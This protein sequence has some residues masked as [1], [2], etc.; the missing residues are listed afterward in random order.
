MADNSYSAFFAEIRDR[1]SS[2]RYNFMSSSGY[3]GAYQ[4]AEI[5]MKNLGY[6]EGDSTGKQDWIGDFTGKDG[7]TSKTKLLTTP[8][9]QDKVFDNMLKLYW[10]YANYDNFHIADH[11]GQTIDGIPVTESLVLAASHL[12]GIGKVREWQHGDREL[13]SGQKTYF[14]GL[15]GYDI[16]WID[17]SGSDDG[18]GPAGDVKSTIIEEF[19]DFIDNGG[20]IDLASIDANTKVAGNQAFIFNGATVNSGDGHIFYKEYDSTDTTVVGVDYGGT[21][22]RFTLKGTD[23]GLGAG[24]FNL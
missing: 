8:A 11:I 18:P 7:V 17:G 6:Y 15:S 10:E 23:L 2:D 5:T 19:T 13:T 22:F 24:D 21:E 12:L 20:K 1:E 14:K 16:P 9:L 4:F 3:L